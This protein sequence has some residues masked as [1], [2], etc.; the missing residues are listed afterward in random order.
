MITKPRATC[1][2][3]AEECAQQRQ[4]GE[5]FPHDEPTPLCLDT[6]Y[7]SGD[8]MRSAAH[9]NRV[10][11]QAVHSISCAQIQNR[12]VREHTLDLLGIMPNPEPIEATRHA[13]RQSGVV[14]QQKCV[15]GRPGH[16]LRVFASA[17]PILVSGYGT[18]ASQRSRAPVGS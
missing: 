4:R 2:T 17:K 12:P 7:R 1:H 16:G 18:A 15:E 6:H 5:I 11:R 10:C 8:D 13:P 9:K 3:S 14:N